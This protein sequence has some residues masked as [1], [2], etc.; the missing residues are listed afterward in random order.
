MRNTCRS[1]MYLAAIY[2]RNTTFSA[3]VGPKLCIS[4]HTKQEIQKFNFFTIRVGPKLLSRCKPKEKYKILIFF[5]FGWAQKRIEVSGG[6][7]C[8][9]FRCKGYVKYIFFIIIY[10]KIDEMVTRVVIVFL[11]SF[12]A[13]YVALL[14]KKKTR[15]KKGNTLLQRHLQ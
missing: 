4:L 3:S 12:A 13:K 6:T 10:S 2:C 7:L 11:E 5:I 15:L 8:S 1:Y 14:G 9:V